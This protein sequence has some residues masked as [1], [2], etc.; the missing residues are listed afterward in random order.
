NPSTD[1]W[2]PTA[3]T[4]APPA[5][6]SLSAVWTGSEM[7]IWGGKANFGGASLNTGSRYNPSTDTWI[8]TST[9]TDC[10]SA[11]SGHYALWTGPEMPMWQSPNGARYHPAA[12]TWGGIAASPTS[13]GAV[14]VW[15]GSEMIVYSGS[16]TPSG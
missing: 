14:P 7:I 15:S 9:G 4:G 10:P 13:I 6:T 11:R 12:N 8:P 5:R 2:V 3:W 1:G 16:S